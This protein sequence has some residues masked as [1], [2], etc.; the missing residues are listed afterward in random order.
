MRM[1]ILKRRRRVNGEMTESV[2]WYGEYRL[3]SM[4]NAKIVNLHCTDKQVAYAKLQKLVTEEEKTENGLLPPRSIRE[5]AKTLLSELLKEY[6]DRLVKLNRTAR[7]VKNNRSRITQ[8]CKDCGWKLLK[9]ITPESFEAWRDNHQNL[10][11]KTLNDYLSITLTF[12]NW[13]VKQERLEKNSLRRVSMLAKHQVKPRRAFTDDELSRLLSVSP[14]RRI[15][16]LL[17]AYTG[18]RRAELKALQWGDVKVEGDKAWLEVR[19]STTKNRKSAVLP[20]R[21]EIVDEL[22]PL[23]PYWMKP[24]NPILR[25]RMPKIQSMRKDMKKAGITYLGKDGRRLDF[26]SLRH[27]YAT[28]LSKAGVPPRVAMEMMR[29]SDIKLTMKTY[30]DGTQLPV[31]EA[32]NKLPWLGV[33]GSPQSDGTEKRTEI[34]VQN[35]QKPSQT[36]NLAPTSVSVNTGASVS[37]CQRKSQTVSKKPDNQN[38]EPWGFEPQTPTMPLW[39]STN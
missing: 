28:N 4:P 20:L 38:V 17:A 18:L 35:G 23:R 12:L 26:H 10:S 16:Y 15:V 8:L 3:D 13:L 2:T 1:R 22:L 19:A 36:G 27:T 7:H 29:H 6:I 21:K 31:A 5:T 30:T 34:L 32:L 11:P 33:A 39:C 14:K 9:D 25:Y 37:V 24:H